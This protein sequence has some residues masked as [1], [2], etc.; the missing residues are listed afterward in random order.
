[1]DGLNLDRRSF[2]LAGVSLTTL[3][4]MAVRTTS[5]PLSGKVRLRF[6]VLADIHVSG[7]ETCDTFKNALRYFDGRR[8]DGVL[9]CGDLAD[10]GL[11]SELGHVADAW[12]EVFP[13]GRRSD[14]E[15]IVNLMHYGDHDMSDIRKRRRDYEA[16][17]DFYDRQAIIRDPAGCWERCFHEK[18][19]PIQ[20]KMVKGYTFVLGHHQYGTPENR[21]GNVVLGVDKVLSEIS[22]DPGKPFF[23]SQHRIYKNTAGGPDVWGQESGIVGEILSQ[24]P[25]AIAFCGHGHVTCTDDRNLWQGAFTALEVP[26]LKYLLQH[27][28]RENGFSLNDQ[29]GSRDGNGGGAVKPASQMPVMVTY[30]GVHRQG[31]FVSVYDDRIVIER[32][33][34]GHGTEEVAPPWTIP[35]VSG[36]PDRSL[37]F[38]ARAA[39]T[40]PPHFGADAKVQVVE[41]EGKDR[42]GVATAQ[43]RV[44]FPP[45]LTD[46]ASPRAMDYEV[47]AEIVKGDV[48][49]IAAQK[50]VYSPNI[51][52]AE[53][54]ETNPVVCI[55]AKDEI[56]SNRDALRFVVRP[57]NVW[58]AKGPKICSH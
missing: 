40:P 57:V 48:V 49:R 6:G 50:R 31:Y 16:R 45:A 24:Y 33:D 19:E 2:I 38:A 41:I 43:F 52:F 27:A 47:T 26:S 32:L 39:R 36:R 8:A 17:K 55:F 22:I 34:F 30:D 23:Y 7:S 25:N 29:Q 15:P 14:G 21:K 46:G 1:M 42:N 11:E 13:D 20:V 5:L 44:C 58:G 51:D 4:G 28:G 10:F 9:V 56:C 54:R 37:T 53:A 18:W 12:Y 3:N 35:L